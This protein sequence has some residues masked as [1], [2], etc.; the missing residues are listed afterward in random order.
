LPPVPIPR[1]Q[2]SLEAENSSTCL[3]NSQQQI[4]PCGPRL[5]RTASAAV[6]TMTGGKRRSLTAVVPTETTMPIR[7]NIHQNNGMEKVNEMDRPPAEIGQITAK[8]TQLANITNTPAIEN[9][10]NAATI[11]HCG[12]TINGN[13]DDLI[14]KNVDE[15]TKDGTTNGGK[16]KNGMNGTASSSPG[17]TIICATTANSP[18]N[19][20]LTPP[21]PP[22]TI[23]WHKT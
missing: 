2:Q 3:G 22:S 12:P 15:G 18:T 13:G 10:Q 9:A 14:N 20:A 4:P 1:Q 17:P 8:I 6:H 16:L 23:G 7:E 5:A 11:N 21:P 19:A